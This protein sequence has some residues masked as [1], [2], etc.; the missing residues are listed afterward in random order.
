MSEVDDIEARL[1]DPVNSWLNGHQQVDFARLV[2]LARFG[3]SSRDALARASCPD[4]E[5]PVY[6]RPPTPPVMRNG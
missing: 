1:R 4:K 2:V 3:E 6:D 5:I